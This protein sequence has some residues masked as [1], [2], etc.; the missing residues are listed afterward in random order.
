MRQ[1]SLLFGNTA[2]ATAMTLAVFFLGLALGSWFW[3]RRSPNVSNP[4]RSFAGLEAGIA[5]TALFYFVVIALFRVIYPTLYQNI[6]FHPLRFALKAGLAMVLILPPAFFMGGT[7]P[8]MAQAIIRNRR[9]FGS[10]A[11]GLYAINT[12][13]AALGAFA[14]GFLFVRLMGFTWTC[15]MAIGITAAT[16]VW[17]Y[18]LGAEHDYSY[19]VEHV[20]FD[21][22][23]APRTPAATIALYAICFLSGFGFLA[24]EVVWTH[25][26]AQIH[27]NSIYSFSAVL[28]L[29]LFALG[30]GAA[31]AAQLAKLRVSPSF[32]L[33]ILLLL[34]GLAVTISPFVFMQATNGFQMMDTGTSLLDFM[35]ALFLKGAYILGLPAF[36]LSIIFPFMMK[37]EERFAAQPGQSLGRLS[38]IDTLGSILGA[39]LCGFFLLEQFGM[40]RTVQLIGALYL[41][42]AV[43]LPFGF[44]KPAIAIR[45][46]SVMTLVALF[47]WLSPADLRVTGWNPARPPEQQQLDLWETHHGTVT[48][49]HDEESGIVIKLNANYWL[50]STGAAW[51][52]HFQGRIPLLAYPQTRSIF[53]LGIGTGISAGGALDPR[54]AQV[55]RV[56]ACEMVPEV[57]TA[58]KK[59]MTGNVRIKDE[60]PID[61]TSGLFSDPRVDIVVADGRQYLMAS[62]ETFDMIN[63]DLFLPYRRGAGS[64]YSREHFQHGKN[65]LHAGGVFVQWIPMYQVT[66]FEFGVIARTM[67]DVFDTVTMWRNNLKPGQE[68]VA[69]IG[70]TSAAPIPPAPS[71]NIQARIEDVAGQNPRNLNTLDLTF[72]EETALIFYCGNLTASKDLFQKYPLNTDDRPV[73]EYA[74]PLSIREKVDGFAPTLVGP[75]FVAL[76]DTLL[77]RCPPDADPMLVQRSPANRRLVTAGA[78]LHRFWLEKAMGNHAQMA[79]AWTR[80]VREWINQPPE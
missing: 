47:T 20:G 40:W 2:H 74:A 66:D 52:Q 67:L 61:Y 72:D 43:L 30:L 57:I 44:S 77:S 79:T 56:V 1:L 53:F 78:A 4:M 75:R 48:V 36:F 65:S 34:G 3:G 70:H 26:L 7:V 41:I 38:A 9:R 14:T 29:V 69:L 10:R 32:L 8:M 63:A 21:D 11:A 73:I 5:V 80:F 68:A 17:A 45:A 49:V 18:R 51:R 50:G 25:L 27:T 76:V 42:A 60:Q 64:L 12:I 16:A 22:A 62:G 37:M 55:S 13:G 46:A 35:Q 24:L 23:P 33:A 19:G 59:Y 58:A 31:T 15:I 28:V 54:F 39:L 6:A 71:E